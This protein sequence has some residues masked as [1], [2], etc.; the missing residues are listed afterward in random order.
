MRVF[1]NAG[2][3]MKLRA[4]RNKRNKSVTE[5]VTRQTTGNWSGPDKALSLKD[6][7]PRAGLA[8]LTWSDSNEVV[9]RYGSSTN[10]EPLY[11]KQGEWINENIPEDGGNPQLT[12]ISRLEDVG[13]DRNDSPKFRAI[14][15]KL[16]DIFSSKAKEKEHQRKTTS[17]KSDKSSLPNIDTKKELAKTATVT[18]GGIGFGEQPRYQVTRLYLASMANI[19]KPQQFSYF[20]LLEL[21]KLSNRLDNLSLSNNTVTVKT[22]SH[23]MRKCFTLI[24]YKGTKSL[25]TNSITLLSFFI[26]SLRISIVSSQSR[27]GLISSSTWNLTLKSSSSLS[28]VISTIYFC[29][30]KF[31][32]FTDVLMTPP[33]L[34]PSHS[35]PEARIELFCNFSNSC[36]FRCV[37][38]GSLFGVANAFI[39]ISAQYLIRSKAILR[40]SWIKLS[41]WKTLFSS[42]EVKAAN[43]KRSVTNAAMAVN[44]AENLGIAVT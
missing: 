35:I 19:Q 39:V 5:S 14:A 23:L 11:T 3:E 7:A 43:A 18:R 32:S 33:S 24:I 27:R 1:Y 31:D 36:S 9:G 29:K 13:I 41:R 25:V 37:K 34:S 28:P 10:D 44:K 22:L 2:A 40:L 8:A 6:A 17:Q 16:E 21:Y 4:E 42:I 26:K 12:K 30:A 38:L 20:V 15:L